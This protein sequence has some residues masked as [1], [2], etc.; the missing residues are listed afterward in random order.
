M[1]IPEWIRTCVAFI[2][3]KMADETYK[4][5]WSVYFVNN[6]RNSSALNY[7]VTAKHVIEKI[8]WKWLEHVYLRLNTR[9]DGAMWLKTDVKNWILSSDENTDVAILKISLPEESFDHKLYPLS[10]AVTVN[11]IST[12]EIDVGDEIF[13]T[14]LFR[15][16][17]GNEKNIPIVRVGN[18]A[19][20][21]EEKIK[22][23]F[24]LMDAFLIEWRSIGWLSWSPVFVNLWVHRYIN[25][26]VKQSTGWTVFFLLGMIYGH[27]DNIDEQ[28]DNIVED[29]SGNNHINVWIAIVTPINKVIEL[30]DKVENI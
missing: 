30:V 19:A 17:Y 7:A 14:G 11:T 24:H 27:F 12:H 18:I 10:W 4:M 21:P 2:G 26:S 25:W 20:M 3:Y 23:K 9:E 5:A 13:I 1:K 8:K 29:T 28:I 16:Y 15:N 6:D 22:T